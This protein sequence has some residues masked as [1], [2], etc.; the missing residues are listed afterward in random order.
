MRSLADLRD[1]AQ[2]IFTSALA[3]VDA[4]KAIRNA[5]R[6]DG[7]RLLIGEVELE[8]ALKPIFIISIGKAGMNMALGAIDQLGDRI[9]QGVVSC[10]E[11]F[12]NALTPQ[13]QVFFGGHPL[14]NDAS[15]HAA[16][17]SFDLLVRANRERGFVLFL[18][19]GGGS[20]M[21]ECP[22]DQT[23]TLTDMRETNRVLVQSGATINEINSVRRTISR[24]KGGALL[25]RTAVDNFTLIV[26]DTNV[27]DET[28][29]ASGP[30][31]PPGNAQDAMPVIERYGLFSALPRAVTEVLR[32]KRKSP[33]RNLVTSGHCVVLDNQSALEAALYKSTE[34]GFVAHIPNGIS[35]QPVAEGCR[36]L[37]EAL[38]RTRGEADVCLISGGEFSCTVKGNGVGGRNLETVLRCAMELDMR[39]GTQAH[40]VVLSAGTDGIDGNSPAAGAI[41]DEKTV[42]RGRAAGLDAGRFLEQS[43]SYSY[44]NALGDT[45]MTGATGTNV[46]DLRLILQSS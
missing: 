34:L 46:R 41:A 26:S 25:S 33:G 27:G 11:T 15:L 2:T 21:I 9:V 17:A 23:I 5:V 31:L 7:T 3:A 4:R 43:D 14:P 45:I 24:V 28:T 6:V 12:A 8:V 18:V 30:T 39:S 1:A 29:V 13:W 10:P 19:S 37:L 42:T 38:Q 20:A 32:S 36:L 44:F 16:D 22:V 35:E 40:T